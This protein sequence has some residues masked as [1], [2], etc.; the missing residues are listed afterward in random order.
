MTVRGKNAPKLR[1]LDVGVMA[2]PVEN[3]VTSQALVVTAR[4]VRADATALLRV[5]HAWVTQLSAHNAMPWSLH[6]TLC[7]VWLHKHT[8]RC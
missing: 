7:V 6:K 4:G 3:W 1:P 8:V 5:A 2:N